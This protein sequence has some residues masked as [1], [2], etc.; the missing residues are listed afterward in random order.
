MEIGMKK[1][2]KKEKKKYKEGKEEKKNRKCD[3]C[4]LL[5]NEEITFATRQCLLRHR[6]TCHEQIKYKCKVLGCTRVF[7]NLGTRSRHSNNPNP[8]V[9]DPCRKQTKRAKQ[10]D[11]IVKKNCKFKRVSLENQ[12]EVEL[13]NNY[14]NLYSSL[15]LKLILEISTKISQ[16]KKVSLSNSYLNQYLFAAKKIPISFLYTRKELK[17]LYKPREKKKFQKFWSKIDE[18]KIDEECKSMFKI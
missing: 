1:E 7:S 10:W 18:N 5:K 2:I 16:R 12:L 3:E 15:P 8:H 13:V 4:S 14:Q 11:V 9:H 17:D 6:K